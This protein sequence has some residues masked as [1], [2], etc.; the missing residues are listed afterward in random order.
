MRQKLRK[1]TR[2]NTI[3]RGGKTLLRQRKKISYQWD[4]GSRKRVRRKKGPTAEKATFLKKGRG[5]S[6]NE[7]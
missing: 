4:Y 3:K 7:D 1:A 5:V 6:R 2:W